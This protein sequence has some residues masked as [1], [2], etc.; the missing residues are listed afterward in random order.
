MKSS[1][2]RYIQ[3][4]SSTHIFGNV[5][6]AKGRNVLRLRGIFFETMYPIITEPKPIN[7][8]LYVYK[9]I[10]LNKDYTTGHI[11]IDKGN[12]MTHQV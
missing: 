12:A 8:H 4:I 11:E 3:Y 6:E 1:P 5:L 9:K 10:E 2:S 7:S